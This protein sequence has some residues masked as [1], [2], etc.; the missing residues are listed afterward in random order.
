MNTKKVLILDD[1]RIMREGL[2]REI[3]KCGVDVEQA[4]TLQEAMEILDRTTIDVAFCDI[5]LSEETSGEDFLEMARA[6]RPELAVVLI[7]CSMDAKYESRLLKKG[8]S[9]CVRKPLFE[10]ECQTAL[11][12]VA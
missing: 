3:S 1:E 12:K 5:R 8:A 7:S 4:S 6:R 10:A 2:A 11:A 9:L